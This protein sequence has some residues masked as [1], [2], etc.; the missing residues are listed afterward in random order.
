MNFFILFCVFSQ[1][2]TIIQ[3]QR[4]VDNR[5]VKNYSR[6][7]VEVGVYLDKYVWNTMKQ[8]VKGSDSVVQRATETMIKQLF[9]D[10]AVLF[11]DSSISKNGGFDL[12]VNGIMIIK[13][14]KDREF[15]PIHETTDQ[16]RQL[17]VFQKYAESRNNPD[18][19]KTDSYDIS[20]LMSGNEE[21]GGYAGY[22][23]IDSVCFFIEVE[24]K[25]DNR[26]VN[27]Y[28]RRTVEVGVYLDKYVWNTMKQQV[29]G[30]NVQRE[31][32]KM[33]KDLFKDAAVLFKDPSISRN[34]GF[35]LKV[36]G[37]MIMKVI[38]LITLTY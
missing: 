36:N 32:E 38:Q 28:K 23:H 37:I 22:S 7:T 30:S 19:K 1:A 16:G 12:V 31:T 25:V 21:G 14:D 8:H 35:D 10:T 3:G 4:K 29:K 18:D 15:S 6:R 26:G 2:V 11:R 5:G 33:V 24:K 27:N 20:F 13:D 9:K 34:G 17:D